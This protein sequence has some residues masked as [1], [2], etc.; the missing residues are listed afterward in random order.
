M[1]ALAET[2]IRSPVSSVTKIEDSA[3]SPSKLGQRSWNRT[4]YWLNS[5]A[6]RAAIGCRPPAETRLA[7]P[8]RREYVTAAF[9]AGPPAEISCERATFFEFGSGGASTR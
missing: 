8:P 3:G 7:R 6:I 2:T 9:V 1:R 5:V 4:P